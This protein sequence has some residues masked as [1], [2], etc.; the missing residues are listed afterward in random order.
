[1]KLWK[2]RFSE[3]TSEL[4][5]KFNAS[6]NFDKRLAAYDIR[7]SI[8]HVRMLA[9]QHIISEADALQIESALIII[10]AE[11]QNGAFTFNIE[12]EDIHMAVE[13][14]LTNLI[15][16]VGGKLHTARSRN[17]QVALD[18]RLYLKDELLSIRSGIKGLVELLLGLA[19]KHIDAVMPGYTHM[20]IAQPIL[21]SHYL[22]AYLQMLLRDYSRF[23][24]VESR[25]NLSPLGSGALAGVSFPI[26][27]R[28]TAESLGFAAPTENSIDSVSDRDFAIETLAA[29]SI[30]MMHLSRFSE[31]IIIYSTSEFNFFEIS[32]AFSTGSSIMPQKKNPDAAELVRGKTGRVYGSLI[33][34]LTAMKGLPLAYNKDL[35]E[36]KEPLFDTIDTVKTVLEIFPLMLASMRINTQNMYKA[37]EKG[38]S[39]ATDL[40]DYLVLKGESFRT[41][42][43]S[44]GRT[45]AYALSKNRLLQELTLDEF[46]QFSAKVDEDIYNFISVQA[47]VNRRNSYGGTSKEAVLIQI[48]NAKKVIAAFS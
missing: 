40:A 2:G 1:M 26:D 16:A 4:L 27:R 46:R 12:D 14:R 29:A 9:R 33:S 18:I 34:L 22:L 6:I 15:G 17:D 37:A 41:A 8:T 7:G 10:S 24:E 30:L 31:E 47:A 32:D 21:F 43:E 36:D 19:E 23:K 38:Y 44:A 3:K 39:T 11:I 35:Q 42:H 20:Q 48:E 28:F 25:L 5:D 45:V 13:S